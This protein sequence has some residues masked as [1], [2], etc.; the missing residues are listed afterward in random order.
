MCLHVSQSVY[1]QF[2]F[3][4]RGEKSN[5]TPVLAVLTCEKFCWLVC[6]SLT[7]SVSQTLAFLPLSVL[8]W[9]ALFL[10]IHT[11]DATVFSGCL[12]SPLKTCRCLLYSCYAQLTSKWDLCRSVVWFFYS[13]NFASRNLHSCICAG[14]I[15]GLVV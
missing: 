12:N 7:C 10:L 8:F 4:I 11:P 3:L 13:F 9:R 2:C 14:R 6:A 5:F 1:S 15:V